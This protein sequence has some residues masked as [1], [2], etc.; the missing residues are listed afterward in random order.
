MGEAHGSEPGARA[1]QLRA[2]GPRPTRR[3]ASPPRAPRAPDAGARPTCSGTGEGLHLP[4]RVKAMVKALAHCLPPP[5]G[6]RAPPG[7]PL[8]TARARRAH[9]SEGA[10]SRRGVVG[11]RARGEA[12]SRAAGGRCKKKL[13][14]RYCQAHRTRRDPLAPGEPALAAAI[15][16][17]RGARAGG[18]TCEAGGL[19]RGAVAGGDSAPQWRR[20]RREKQP[21]SPRR[22][23]LTPHLA[24]S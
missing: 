6:P 20:R 7:R 5:A 10:G 12:A 9:T 17:L 21:R 14:T 13:F 2:V 3:A 11:P 24:A 23:T 4:N 19:G 15:C 8:I 22:G 18:G 1:P 16:S